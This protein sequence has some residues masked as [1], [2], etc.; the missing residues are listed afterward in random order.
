MFTSKKHLYLFVTIKFLISVLLPTIVVSEIGFRDLQIGK[1]ELSNIEEY[2]VLENEY[3]SESLNRL[4]KKFECYGDDD[5]SFEFGS[6]DGTLITDIS[7][8]SNIGN[9]FPPTFYVDRGSKFWGIRDN[10]SEKY[11][12]LDCNERSFEKLM[13]KEKIF[14]IEYYVSKSDDG[15]LN[16]VTLR[17]I[18]NVVGDHYSWTIGYTDENHLKE[19]TQTEIYQSSC[20]GEG[21][22]V[23]EF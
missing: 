19:R 16:W 6:V 11:I 12:R 4:V 10:L 9:Y 15:R 13:L 1:T 3:F 7:I 14:G 21:F 23:E 22:R 8:R 18:Q 2:C 20:G 17:V 5:Y